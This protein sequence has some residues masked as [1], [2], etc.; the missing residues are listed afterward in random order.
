MNL[1]FQLRNYARYRGSEKN[2]IQTLSPGTQS[3]RGQAAWQDVRKL[4]GETH[5]AGL[6]C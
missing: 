2:M 3:D 4:S 6:V 1:S 5:Q